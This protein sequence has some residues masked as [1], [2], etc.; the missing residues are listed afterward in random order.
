MGGA[1]CPRCPV[2]ASSGPA[3]GLP[4]G[5]VQGLGGTVCRQGDG[6]VEWQ[7]LGFALQAM[8]L[9]VLA[10]RARCLGEYVAP[11]GGGHADALAAAGIEYAGQI[12]VLGGGT[13]CG[14]PLQLGDCNDDQGSRE[15]PP[16][17]DLVEGIARAESVRTKFYP[18]YFR[19]GDFNDEQG[20]SVE[21]PRAGL[22]EG[23]VRTDLYSIGDD[24]DGLGPDAMPQSVGFV[25]DATLDQGVGEE[26]PVRGLLRGLKG[27]RVSPCRG[28]GGGPGSLHAVAARGAQ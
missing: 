6:A 25:G 3:A 28:Q 21:P 7:R 11:S 2:G 8:E 4:V 26:P 18:R 23:I 20:S 1:C 17:A 12:A 27:R 13:F 14:G 22:R 10:M 5:E 16:R 19:I 24:E 9:A 15:E